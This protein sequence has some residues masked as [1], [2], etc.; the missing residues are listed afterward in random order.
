MT[1]SLVGLVSIGLLD[2]HE[3]ALSQQAA[4]EGCFFEASEADQRGLPVGH[5]QTEGLFLKISLMLECFLFGSLVG[6]VALLFLRLTAGVPILLIPSKVKNNPWN[7]SRIGSISIAAEISQYVAAIDLAKFSASAVTICRL[8]LK[9]FLFP[10]IVNTA[11]LL[12]LFVSHNDKFFTYSKLCLFVIE[13]TRIMESAKL[14]RSS[15]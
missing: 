1:S 10:M 8:W 14:H 11:F 12:L 3:A 5:H 9:S 2:A 6:I 13:N 15:F 7:T 4:T